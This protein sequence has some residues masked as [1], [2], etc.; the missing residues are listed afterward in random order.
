MEI[1]T[2]I[3]HVSNPRGI[4]GT[5]GLDDA[6]NKFEA[7]IY[8]LK[9]MNLGDTL[10]EKFKNQHMFICELPLVSMLR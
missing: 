5:L 4:L 9:F 3:F 6:F 8:I 10:H 2:R 1:S 7:L